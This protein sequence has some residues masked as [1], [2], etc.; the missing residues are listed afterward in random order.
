MARSR[1]GSRR[2]ARATSACTDLLEQVEEESWVAEATALAPI[3][4]TPEDLVETAVVAV[5]VGDGVRRLLASLGVQEIVAGGQSM[6]PSTAQI[7]DAVERC[8]VAIR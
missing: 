4:H 8:P 1:P 2:A 3:V 7:L 6:N 5:A